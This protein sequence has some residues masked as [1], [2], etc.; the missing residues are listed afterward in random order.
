MLVFQKIA[1]DGAPYGP[2]FK[3]IDFPRDQI[4]HLAGDETGICSVSFGLLAATPKSLRSK[5]KG[6]AVNGMEPTPDNIK[7]GKYLIS[8][9][10]VLGTKGMP[11]GDVKTFIDFMLSPEGQKFVGK[12]FVPVK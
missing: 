8:R 7:F 9:P 1:M 11:K 10:L 3:Q 2:G 5:V 12:H 4:V 6:V